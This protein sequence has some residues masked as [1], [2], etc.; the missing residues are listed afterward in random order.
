MWSGTAG[1]RATRS[2]YCAICRRVIRSRSCDDMGRACCARTARGEASV[3]DRSYFCT[4]L[5]QPGTRD[6]NLQNEIAPAT[7][8]T[9]VNVDYGRRFQSWTDRLD[10]AQDGISGEK[11]WEKNKQ[12]FESNT[13]LILI[14]KRKDNYVS[15]FRKTHNFLTKKIYS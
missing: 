15:R 3:S 4:D 5:R 2:V 12:E 13:N 14:L 1:R 6:D 11:N 9:G 7:D 8:R 10:G